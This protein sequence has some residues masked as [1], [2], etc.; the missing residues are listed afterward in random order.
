MEPNYSKIIFTATECVLFLTVLLFFHSGSVISLPN[1]KMLSWYIL[2]RQNK[3][4][5]LAFHIYT[6]L[7]SIKIQTQFFT[8]HASAVLC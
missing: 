3:F 6:Q 5:L 4:Y 7:A 8:S 2:Y 1:L